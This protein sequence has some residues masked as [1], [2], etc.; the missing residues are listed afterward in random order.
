MKIQTKATIRGFDVEVDVRDVLG[1]IIEKHTSSSR[2]SDVSIRT[3]KGIRGVYRSEDI[4][5]H[6]SPSWRHTLI[7]DTPEGIAL[8]EKKERA[9]EL[10]KELSTLLQEI[11]DE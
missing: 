9:V 1:K 8:F 6:G 3:E 10:A 5:Y 7:T 2:H 11:G 4:S